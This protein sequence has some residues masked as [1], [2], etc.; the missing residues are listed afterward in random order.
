METTSVCVP[1]LTSVRPRTLSLPTVSLAWGDDSS[2]KWLTARTNT[3]V[4]AGEKHH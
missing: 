4:I 2:D 1:H 3:F